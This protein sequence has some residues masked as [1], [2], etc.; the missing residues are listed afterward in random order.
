MKKKIW[1]YIKT[2]LI[3]L[4]I[5]IFII[6]FGNK[7]KVLVLNNT[8]LQPIPVKKNLYQDAHCGMPLISSKF[9]AEVISE[10][11]KTWFFHDPGSVPLWLNNI[12]KKLK[13]KISIWFFTIDTKTWKKANK[14]WFSINDSTPMD[15]GFAAY[16]KKQDSF[17]TY[18]EM[19]LRM[20]RGE[21]KKNPKI[22]KMLEKKNHGNY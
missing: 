13:K 22:R 7:K 14:V 21:N 10:D 1:K 17:I 15:Y 5:I 16:E 11:G 9:A 2:I 6:V 20:L 19:E 4:I 8:G 3:F 12:E 18:R